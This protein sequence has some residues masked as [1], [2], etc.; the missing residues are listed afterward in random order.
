MPADYFPVSILQRGLKMTNDPPKGIKANLQ[1]TY[2]N[3]ITDETITSL[4]L[5]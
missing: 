2:H 5:G 4:N 1:R 3:I